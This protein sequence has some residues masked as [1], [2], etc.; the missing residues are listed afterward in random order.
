MEP[1]KIMTPEGDI[2]DECFARKWRVRMSHPDAMFYT[3]VTVRARSIP[4]AR[5]KAERGGWRAFEFHDL[6]GAD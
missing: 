2:E 1:L 5:V 4:E 3:T 6:M